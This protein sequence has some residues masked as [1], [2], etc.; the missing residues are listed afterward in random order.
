MSDITLDPAVPL[1]PVIAKNEN[2]STLAKDETE[3]IEESKSIIEPNEEVK[4]S[5]PAIPPTILEEPVVVVQPSAYNHKWDWAWGTSAIVASLLACIL[6]PFVQPLGVFA[7]LAIA[8]GYTAVALVNNK[9]GR[10][11]SRRKLNKG[12]GVT[13]LILGWLSFHWVIIWVAVII[14][15]HLLGGLL[16]TFGASALTGGMEGLLSGGLSGILGGTDPT[17]IPDIGGIIGSDPTGLPTDIPTDIPTDPAQI[18]DDV[19]KSLEQLKEL[20]KQLGVN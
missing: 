12:L 8:L 13:G 9:N 18:G 15:A 2:N 1:P 14:I 20:L 5:I 16:A 17:Q 3:N 11:E 19:N 4:E 7:I 10:K 6:V